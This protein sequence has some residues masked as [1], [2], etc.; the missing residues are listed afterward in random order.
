MGS[1]GYGISRHRYVRYRT[2]Y[3]FVH[4]RCECR[5]AVLRV[6]VPADY[7]RILS[8]PLHWLR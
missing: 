6:M 4:Q 1:K 5:A 7:G 3:H 2:L 8:G